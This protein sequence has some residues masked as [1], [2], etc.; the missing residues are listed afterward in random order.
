MEYALQ[1]LSALT[2][3]PAVGAEAQ[4]RRAYLQFRS[5]RYGAAL[6]DAREAAG[7]GQHA[8]ER[9]LGWYLAGQAAQTL[10]D[11]RS[12]DAH[13]AAALEARPH[14]QSA[15]LALAALRF[16]RGDAQGA[17]DLVDASALRPALRRRPV[18]AVPLWGL[19]EAGRSRSTSPSSVAIA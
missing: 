6:A 4:I 10:G 1:Q 17:A 5:G 11:L 19:P 16:Q 14:S 3:D 18:A 15:T 13:Y 7:R 8:D 9:Y 2:R 12:A